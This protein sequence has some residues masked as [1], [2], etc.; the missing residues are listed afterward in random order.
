MRFFGPS[1][2]KTNKEDDKTQ[3]KIKINKHKERGGELP[4]D[5]NFG[6][7]TQKGQLDNFGAQKNQR[8]YL[9]L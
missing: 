4:R 2:H 6:R 5:R 7:I 8:L 1:L 3:G 9:L